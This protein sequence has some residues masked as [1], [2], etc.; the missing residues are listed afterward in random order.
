MPQAIYERLKREDA[1]FTGSL[2]AVK[3]ACAKHRRM[4]GVMP[5]DVAI[6]V[7]TEPGAIAQVDLCYVGKLLDPK[8]MV[9]RKAWMFVMVLG[10]SR[11]QYFEICF[12]QKVE[13]C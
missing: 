2:S 4:R 13:T 11:H 12:D 1:N 3:R 9:L 8:T 5:E 10:H 6:P 7:M